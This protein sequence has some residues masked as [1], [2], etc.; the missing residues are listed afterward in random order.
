MTFTYYSATN[1]KEETHALE[2]KGLTKEEAEAQSTLMPEAREML[3]SGKPETKRCAR[4]WEMMNNWVY[5]GFNETYKM[6]GVDFDK[7]YYE[8]Q[9]YLEGKGKVM[10]GLEKGF[11]FKKEDGS[12]LG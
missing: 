6:M 8:S 11:F 3:V 1:Y 4:L 7:I 5:A 10:E 9:T 2:A 12:V